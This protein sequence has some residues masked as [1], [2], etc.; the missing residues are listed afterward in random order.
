[1]SYQYTNREDGRN[2]VEVGLYQ[3]NPPAAW[4]FSSHQQ[5]KENETL[6]KLIGY[7]QTLKTKAE[8]DEIPGEHQS[9]IYQ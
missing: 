1:M 4:K 5:I 2:H 8:Q 9:I 7:W 3:T 6:T